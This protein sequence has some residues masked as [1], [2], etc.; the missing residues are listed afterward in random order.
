MENCPPSK[1]YLSKP[2]IVLLCIAH[3][4]SLRIVKASTQNHPKKDT[5]EQSTYPQPR[6]INAIKC[7]LNLRHLTLF[8]IGINNSI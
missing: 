5:K 6:H 4:H 1:V 8:T 2:L 7:L 3:H